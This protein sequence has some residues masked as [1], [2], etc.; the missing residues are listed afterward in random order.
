[1]A[2]QKWMNYKLVVNKKA[3]QKPCYGGLAHSASPVGSGTFNVGVRCGWWIFGS[4]LNCLV[5]YMDS[6]YNTHCIVLPKDLSCN[7]QSENKRDQS[8][9]LSYES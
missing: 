1:M 2:I 7:T 3:S 9:Q 6:L 5:F 8:S 4:L